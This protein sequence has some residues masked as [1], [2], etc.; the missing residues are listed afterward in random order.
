MSYK[1]AFNYSPAKL[2]FS[3]RLQ[4]LPIVPFI[5]HVLFPVPLGKACQQIA[6]HLFLN[7]CSHVKFS[8]SQGG[9]GADNSLSQ[10]GRISECAYIPSYLKFLEMMDV[11]LF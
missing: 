6:M 9:A 4:T 5:L 10:D 7:S 1:R 2:R 8:S 3:P 11:V